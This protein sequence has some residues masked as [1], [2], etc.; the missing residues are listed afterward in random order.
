M[1]RW[2][3][4]GTAG[5]AAAVSLALG[6]AF[7]GVI[8][9]VAWWPI[10]GVLGAGGLAAAE[11][12]ERP[13][14]QAVRSV[15]WTVAIIAAIPIV[16]ATAVVVGALLASGEA[17]HQVASGR[18][19]LTRTDLLFDPAWFSA[20]AG[21]AALA[22]A[23]VVDG[24]RWPSPA[25]RDVLG[26]LA[27][28]AVL[29]V[30]ALLALPLGAVMV[31][32]LSTAAV[33]AALAWRSDRPRVGASATLGTLAVAG[34]WSVGPTSLE[35]LAVAAAI[36]LG[37]LAVIRGIE[38]GD[39]ALAGPGA[40]LAAA[41]VVGEAVL[42]AD[43]LIDD[44]TWAWAVGSI[45]AA[46]AG[47]AVATSGFGRAMAD[48]TATDFAGQLRRPAPSARPG[49]QDASA[50]LGGTSREDRPPPPMAP[51]QGQTSGLR[52]GPLDAGSVAVGVASAMLLAGH[53]LAVVRV[54]AVS[55]GPATA[56]ISLSLAVGAAALAGI[57]GSLRRV[58]ASWW[59]WAVGATAEAVVLI[60][61][62][63]AQAAMT[64]PEAYTLPIAIALGITAWLSAR[65]RRGGPARV[66]SWQL[67]GPALAMA[68][69]PAVLVALADPGAVR[70]IVGL[71]AG[72][73]VLAV[74]AVMRR[75]APIDVGSAT[76]VALVL[77]G[78]LPYVADVPRWISFGLVGAVLVALG[79]TFEQ[80]RRDLHQARRHYAALR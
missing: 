36:V 2:S 10:M 74:G 27:T 42:V 21:L 14:R 29:V 12:L 80:R 57:A 17:W 26:A 19:E 60:W 23:V 65:A 9:D 15:S 72:A 31:I 67:E 3:A 18:I 25:R 30:V 61:F 75:R 37:A 4:A 68:L 69:A 38:L 16:A 33:L 39:G 11:L 35:L 24:R 34:L 22:A 8:P 28:L 70:Q 63:L 58:L 20:L 46:V 76:L 13:R 79:A 41:A 53:V 48:R 45:V 40:A 1:A 50:E 78:L 73:A 32:T 47:V 49:S 43:A 64:V 6:R 54:D 62:R 5:A 44:P 55:S 71:V 51:T 56:P 52:T 66:P 7:G 77:Q 59:V